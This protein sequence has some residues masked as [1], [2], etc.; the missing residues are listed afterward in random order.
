MVSYLWRKYADYV[1]IKWERTLLW[2]T[3]DPYRRSKSSTP[4][5]TL[6]T[7]FFL[8]GGGG[9]LKAVL[10]KDHFGEAMPL[11]KPMFYYVPWKV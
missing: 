1:Y 5:V 8:E 10:S 9:E 2:N 3:V 11:M 4:L 6:Y 7:F